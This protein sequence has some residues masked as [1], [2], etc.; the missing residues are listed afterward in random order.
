MIASPAQSLRPVPSQ[1]EIAS[2]VVLLRSYAP[3][4]LASAVRDKFDIALL[5]P[6]PGAAGLAPWQLKRAK[7]L[8]ESHL[9][10]GIGV[11]QVAGACGLSRSHFS[12]AFRTSTGLSPHTWL[13]HKRV[14]KACEM[15]RTR[16]SLCEI[17]LTC[18]FSDQSHFTRLFRRA[19][20]TTPR[21][22][23]RLHL[24]DERGNADDVSN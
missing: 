17:A 8:F 10:G 6:R 19:V 22:W 20:G 16:S 18:G 1:Q 14:A 9:C 11:E 23:R 15:M 5:E 4:A 7:S 24:A 2:A 13:I 3:N 12:H 21:A